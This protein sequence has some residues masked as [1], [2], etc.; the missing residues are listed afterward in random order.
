M[1]FN[2]TD[3]ILNSIDSVTV[4]VGFATLPADPCRNSVEC[5][6]ASQTIRME[7]SVTSFHFALAMNAFHFVFLDLKSPDHSL[8]SGIYAVMMAR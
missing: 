5:K 4:K 2:R 7:G 6:M 3:E 1:L 8:E